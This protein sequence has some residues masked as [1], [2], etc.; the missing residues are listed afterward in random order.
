M[1]LCHTIKT[2]DALMFSCNSTT[3][4]LLRTFV[5]SQWNHSG[6]AIRFIEIPDPNDPTK[7]I[8]QISLDETGELYILETNTG[9]R[10]DDVYN[11]DIVG[12][13]FSKASWVFK[14]YNVVAV[15]RLHEIFRTP[16][17][18]RLTFEFADKFRGIRFPTASLPFVAVWL[19][20][21]MPQKEK[22]GMFCSEVMAHYY[23]HCIGSQYQ[24][25]TGNLFDGKLRN[26]FGS[27]APLTE[28][29]FTPGHYT[30]NL[31]PNASIFNGFHEIVY[32]QHADLLYTIIQPLLILLFIFVF[33]SYILPK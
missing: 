19:G 5:S 21:S 27:E 28:D 26:L 24:Q 17:L 1:D 4:F 13:G 23:S 7:I 6:I 18:S 31:T 8:K 14:Y 30:Y 15:R 11:I 22:C 20:I 10:R 9:I 16:E 12:V 32:V 25:L 2:G 3:G 29:T 33:F